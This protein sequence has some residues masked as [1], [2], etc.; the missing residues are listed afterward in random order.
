MNALKQLSLLVAVTLPVGAAQ[1]KFATQT[2]TVPDGF[3]V[4]LV[5]GPPAVNRPISIAFD[6]QGRLYA[7]D[8]SGLIDRAPEQQAK[9]PHRIVRLEDKDGDG[10]YE[11]S[12]VFAEN[13]M[14]PQGALFH[15]G[16]LFVAAPPHIWKLTDTD[17]DGRSDRREVW[18]DG[19]TLTGCANDVHGPYLGPDGWFYWTKGAF[20]E[21]KHTLG[22]GT[23]FVSRAAH[24]Y[25][26]RPDGSRLEPIMTG[27]MDNPV[28]LTFAANGE[29]F[30]SGTFFTTPTAGQRDGLIHAIYGG[31][32]GKENAA[33]SG[34]PRTGDLMPIMTHMGAAAPCGSTTYRSSVFGRDYTDNLFVCT[35]NL[36]K[37]SR[38]V[39]VPDG[40]TFKTID[41]DFVTSDSPDFHPTDV[42]E[43]ADGS[44]L[45]VDTG[46]WYKICC[47]TSQLSKPE[48][49]GGIYRVRKT[50][51]PRVADPRGLALAW[52][53]LTA[54]ELVKLLDDSRPDVVERAQHGLGKL[55]SAAVPALAVDQP[56]PVAS[57]NALWTLARIDGD[58]AR[59]VVRARLTSDDPS[60]R[61]TAMKV[62]SL[63]RDA[64]AFDIVYRLSFEQFGLDG[65]T[66]APHSEETLGRLRD[67]RA[68]RWLYISAARVFEA[69]RTA[70][71]TPADPADRVIEHSI[72]YALIEIGSREE[73]L[74]ALDKRAEM[75]RVALV[76]LDQ[77]PN[78][79]LQPTDVLPF[80]NSENLIRKQTAAWI[81][82]HR[83]AWGDALAQHFRERLAKSDVEGLAAQL[84]PLA[85]S[86]AIQ[87]LLADTLATPNHAIAITAMRAAGLKEAPA[88]WLTALMPLLQG[89]AHREAVATVRALPLPKATPA[90][91]YTALGELGRN[92]MADSA[93]RLDALA[94][95]APGLKSL[96]SELFAFL[97]G[98]L[99]A[100]QPVFARSTAATAL[101]RA[102]LSSEQQLRL[103]GGMAKAGALEAAK[104]LP[105]FERQ[106]TETL[107]LTLLSSLRASPGLA[108]I[109]A[110]QL[111]LVVAK[112]PTRVQQ[113]AAPLL[114]ALAT[115]AARQNAR[116]D[117]LLPGVAKGDISRGHLVFNSPKTACTVCHKIGYAGGLLGPDLTTIGRIRSER[118]LLEAIVF[119]SA[120]QVRG[121]ESVTVATKSSESHT[122][123][124]SK[125][126][127][128]EIV[129]A[130]GPESTQ[131]IARADIAD[132]QPSPVSPM[133]PGMDAVLTQQELADLVAFLKSR[134]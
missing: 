132:I 113:V 62:T 63:W 28:G 119:P 107:G 83:P 117:E 98:Q 89:P 49:L 68:V 17:G 105:A 33:T 130:T 16:S 23:P 15:D 72:I 99:D 70:T 34:H 44:L 95:A 118:E 101:A 1:F 39:L 4:E 65:G 80:L 112:Y 37:V 125:D 76:A 103:A 100:S 88:A 53:T 115:D 54:P 122:G 82:G 126:D 9:K 6:P 69:K 123:I 133:P 43:D 121:Y 84:A 47:P 104:L 110:S 85:S 77:M 10:R 8:S 36:R 50:G 30:L 116:I 22:D 134:K 61:S 60:V 71:G 41:S 93:T 97:T 74:P 102:P 92:S 96:D 94:L 87:Q 11:T 56:T 45:I 91:F 90:A 124:I 51:A 64:K 12:V 127:S 59:A 2:L 131:R 3:T 108:G 109:R 25:R 78:G 5:A 19:G 46:G 111:S 114:A 7:T 67:P 26:A 32:Y 31:V 35:F 29:R 13:M 48:V 18:W 55:G 106:P 86:P 38:H 81:V 73:L 58:A 21:Q 40:A 75:T 79:N 24:I 27:G 129:L 66:P 52:E 14:F 20:A 128:D 42:L 120:T 57:R